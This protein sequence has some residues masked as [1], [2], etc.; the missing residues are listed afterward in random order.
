MNHPDLPLPC[1]LL[2]DSMGRVVRVYRDRVD[3]A[4]ILKDSAVIDASPAEHLARALP[5]GGILGT[6]PRRRDYVPYGRELLDQGL[7]QA[8]FAFEQAAQGNPSASILYRLGSLLAKAGQ[9]QKARDAY[10]RALRMQP[11]LPGPSN[12]LG[13]LLV[14]SGDLEGAIAQQRPDRP[15]APEL[16]RQTQ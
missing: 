5:F 10:E 9:S 15:A 12:D 2:L 16:R 6:V 1:T 11:G 7:A 13:A 8:A 4:A 3:V 14:E